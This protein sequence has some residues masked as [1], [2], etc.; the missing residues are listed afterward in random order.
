MINPARPPTPSRP[1]G[2]SYC[3]TCTV[4]SNRRSLEANPEKKSEYNAVSY[5]RHAPERKRYQSAY[6]QLN[7]DRI[8][9][10]RTNLKLE[11]KALIEK[12]KADPCTDCGR[13]FDACAMDFDHVH[14]DKTDNIAQ[15]VNAAYSIETLKAEIA[16]CELVCACCHRVRTKVRGQAWGR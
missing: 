1:S 10:H 2:Y 13:T 12:I 14:G 7:G 16:K 9:D 8:K 15:M 11:K 4:A 6:R 3:T 5:E